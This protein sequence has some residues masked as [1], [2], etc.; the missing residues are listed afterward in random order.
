MRSGRV[1]LPRPENQHGTR[2]QYLKGHS[3]RRMRFLTRKPSPSEYATHLSEMYD[4]GFDKTMFNEIFPAESV[5]LYHS[6]DA[7]LAEWFAFGAFIVTYCLWVVFDSKEKIFPI[8]D[9]FQ[10]MLVNRLRKLSPAIADQFF[11][12]ASAREEE[13]MTAYRKIKDGTSMSIFYSRVGSHIIGS[14]DPSLDSLDMPQLSDII[15]VVGLSTFGTK[16]MVA[17]KSALEKAK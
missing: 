11:K 5:S 3:A 4:A 14:F 13:Y 16:A 12:I 6:A 2:G 8:L 9:S 10:P 1:Q 17:I 7:A 15:Q